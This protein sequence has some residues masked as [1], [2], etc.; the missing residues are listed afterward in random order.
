MTGIAC[1]PQEKSLQPS[2]SASLGCGFVHIIEEADYM[3]S[4][5]HDARGDGGILF[6]FV[7]RNEREVAHAPVVVEHVQLRVAEPAVTHRDLYLNKNQRLRSHRRE[8]L[9]LG[10]VDD[11]EI[12]S[13]SSHPHS[14]AKH[15]QHLVPHS[16]VRTLITRHACVERSGGSVTCISSI[17]APAARAP[18]AS[19]TISPQPSPAQASA[20]QSASGLG[21]ATLASNDS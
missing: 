10:G 21:A 15:V 4:L 9:L 11:I 16:R 1:V 20:R 18:Y 12:R 8:E 17:G 2:N 19:T 6:A 5:L 3:R 7:S 13:L 14:I